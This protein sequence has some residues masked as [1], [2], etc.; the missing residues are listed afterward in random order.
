MN[1]FLSYNKNTI[2][3]KSSNTTSIP[4]RPEEVK[5]SLFMEDL[6]EWRL[7]VDGKILA[8]N[9]IHNLDT[10]VIKERRRWS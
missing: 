9:C 5:K 10:I 8:E 6:K 4:W 2:R 3:T 7:Q 1:S